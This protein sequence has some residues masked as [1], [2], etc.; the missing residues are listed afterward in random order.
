MTFDDA[1]LD[2]IKDEAARLK[3]EWEVLAAVTLVESGGRPLWD[4]LCP[5]RIEGHYFYRLLPKEKRDQG[6]RTGLADP[7]AGKVKNPARMADRYA[8]LQRMIDLDEEAAL[9][10]CS[11]G[12]GQVMG[13]HWRS[14]GYEN[15]QELVADAKGSIAGQVRLMGRFIERNL[16]VDELRRKDWASFALKYNGKGAL[17]NGYDVK[18]AAAYSKIVKD[19][20][21]YAYALN[22]VDLMLERG[23]KGASVRSFQNKLHKFGYYNGALDGVFGGGTEAAVMD[24]Q[25]D[26]GLQV[27]GRAGPIT[28]AE[29]SGWTAAGG[30]GP[31]PNSIAE[32]VYKN[33][34]AIRNRPCT[35]HLVRA[36]GSA[37]YAVFGPG[38]QAQI[39]S[40]GQPRFGTPG[41]RTG[42]IRHDD[43]G[44]GG[45]AL[46]AWIIDKSGNR[47]TG[48]PL[49]K[50]GQYWLASNLGG[51]GLEMATGG[52]HL[53]EWTTPPPGGGM[54]WMYPYAEKQSWGKDV[55]QMLIDGTRG[56]M[57]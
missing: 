40:G 38:M 31:K 37:V 2:G 46:D 13:D 47:L 44:L 42:S 48:K 22:S 26:A 20:G 18:M 8:Q 55:R 52:I 19:A 12:L 25:R 3:I 11:W 56:I 35:T 34:Q 51:C 24:F 10:S 23:A 43:Y 45:R 54:Y 7:S 53:D 4:G 32:V 30:T 29:L 21:S 6:I 17:K 39:Y 9:A 36:L 28:M 50:L 16:L 15:V 14:L 49:A 41:K 33:Q 57:P 5:I 27:D 1:T